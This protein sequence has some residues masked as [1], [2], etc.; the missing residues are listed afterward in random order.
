MRK[1]E[2][3]FSVVEFLIAIVIIV[4][5][6][7]IGWFI[8]NKNHN[9]TPTS[10]T[11]YSDCISHGG[12]AL[13]YNDAVQF[14]ACRGSGSA[15]Y[16]QYSA[17]NL[18]NISQNKTTT[19]PNQVVSSSSDASDLINYLTYNYT[20]CNTG[21]PNGSDVTGYY[22]IIKEIPSGWALL[23]YGCSNN[24]QSQNDSTHM[25]AMKLSSGWVELSPTNNFLPNGTPSCL[26]VDMFKVPETLTSQ[27]YQ[28]TGYSNGSLRSV[29]YQWIVSY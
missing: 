19:V 25:I 20:G 13:T 12:Q 6:V 9:K 29:T 1:N 18:P 26:L 24:T 11:G 4:L 27:C 23:N 14:N 22:K 2:T 16:L 17:Q 3:G 28:N 21:R 8:Y 5:L 15:L 7:A 10:Y